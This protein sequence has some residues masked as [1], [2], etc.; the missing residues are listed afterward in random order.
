MS[1]VLDQIVAGKRLEVAERRI[2]TSETE[3]RRRIADMD[4]P[5]NFFAAVTRDP[6]AEHRS[7]R[8]LVNLIAEVKRASPS[9]G[10]IRTDFDPVDI[11]RQFHLAGADAISCLTD[12]P[13]FQGRLEY[14]QQIR[15]AIPLPVLRKDFIIDPWQ[16]FET[17]AC[18]AD[19]MLLIAECLS[20][21]E[22]I[23]LSILATE[24]K[25]TTLIE[26]HSMENLMR[27]RDSVIGFP[28]KSYSLLGIN[29]RDLQT[30]S[31]DV[32]NTLR[33]AELVEN[34]DNLVSES[35]IRTRGHVQKLAD[36]GI[37]ATLV[38]ET[39]MRSGDIDAAI[40]E[41]FWCETQT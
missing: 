8:K 27:V 2:R 14:V 12:E 29:N 7:P 32:N 21:P 40:R 28:M 41:L 37:R 17:R 22:M 16:V 30:M 1:G 6:A 39:L 10:T 38:G 4:S 33:M 13:H 25:L 26:V 11:A 36:A 18:G 5:R 24:L 20:T 15:S 3:L 35:G 31:V 23:D 9:A 34:R 19:A